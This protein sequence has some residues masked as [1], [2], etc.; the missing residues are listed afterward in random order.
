M[1]DVIAA[2]ASTPPERHPLCDPIEA[3]T[4]QQAQ[5]RVE[6]LY[7]LLGTNDDKMV[8][9]FLALYHLDQQQLTSFLASPSLGRQG[10]RTDWIE[11]LE[12]VVTTCTEP[13]SQQP[14][15][16]RALFAEDPIPFEEIVLPFLRY[17]RQHYFQRT[18]MQE[19]SLI[20]E[21]AQAI[22]EHWLL[23]QLAQV[24]GTVFQLEFS[25]FRAQYA[26]W[27]LSPER[28]HLYHAFVARYRGEGLLSFFQEYSA[29]ARLLILLVEQWI[30]TCGEFVSRLAAD[31]DEIAR[32]FH[33]GQPL[34]AVVK[35]Q[36]GCSDRHHHGRTVFLLSFAAGMK[37]VYK[38]RS[39]AVDQAFFGL[40]TWCNTQGLS[41]SLE[42]LHVLS[43]DTYGWME[44]AEHTSCTTQQEVE[45]Y[46][47]RAGM[48][49]CML[50]VLGG[51]DMH[52][53]N[54]VACGE[55]PILI[56]LETV[57]APGFSSQM[58]GKVL[59]ACSPQPDDP[60][61]LW[62]TVL[63]TS[64]LP[65]WSS[66]GDTDHACDI[67][68][69]GGVEGHTH[70][71]PHRSWKHINTDAMRQESSEQ[72]TAISL[73]TVLLQGIPET[74]FAYVEQVVTGFCRLYQFLATHQRELCAPEGPLTAFEGCS[75]R[76]VC[77]GTATYCNALSILN[78]PAWLRE[79][80][81]RWVE[82]QAFNQPWLTRDTNPCFLKLAEA[83]VHA[84]ECLDVPWFGTNT[85]SHDLS[86]DSGETIANL[87]PISA[88]E[89]ARARLVRL[90]TDDMS[91]QACLIRSTFLTARPTQVAV[92]EALSPLSE[93]LEQQE[94]FSTSQLV[95]VAQQIAQQLQA[96]AFLERREDGTW[97]GL[98]YKD[99]FKSFCVQPIGFNLYEGACGIALFLALL[100]SIT[101][102]NRYRELVASV[103][104]P[105]CQDLAT[106]VCSTSDLSDNSWEIG[107]A[108][109]LGSFI[110]ALTHIGMWLCL[111]ELHEAARQ[112]A[113]L[114]TV[115]RVQQDE[116]FDVIAGSAGAI[117]GLLCLYE[118]SGDQQL[119]EQALWC[120]Q[121]LLKQ[122]VA[123]QSGLRSWPGLKKH[124]LT[125][126]SHGAAGIA[127]AL[128]RLCAVSG[129]DVLREA[130]E[131]AISFERDLFSPEVGNWPD[132]REQPPDDPQAS[133]PYGASWCHGAP[134][135]GLARLGGLAV[136]DTPQVRRDLTTA[137]QTTQ[138][139]GLLTLDNLC[140]GNFGRIELLVAASQHLH[141]PQLLEMARRWS[142][143]LICRARQLDGFQMFSQLPR[144][145]YNP[146]L[147][148][149]SAGIGYQ[150]LRVAFPEQVPSILL[151]Q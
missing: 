2:R 127:Y 150:L 84:L 26:L 113:S 43:R 58:W 70:L 128:L 69:L 106:A 44:Y 107:G 141:Q 132:L 50:Y 111:P 9:R 13:T 42:M 78:Q 18:P 108:S 85:V 126:F 72:P 101:G 95:E 138:T 65:E 7:T 10:F 104:R 81:D 75:L 46:Y 40:L 14:D 133:I 47:L 91:R 52:N 137:L 37:L 142:S 19:A 36:M 125:G 57:I 110:Y 6:R 147:F 41:P 105:L 135:I 103:L 8:Q 59:S 53:S 93:E 63:H 88:L 35:L 23:Q 82:L 109:G 45:N 117:L 33:H 71:H 38:P 16:D 151:W 56:D 136:L 11:V 116:S 92:M 90:H 130:A 34:G 31:Q 119:I 94:M 115:A 28:R 67:S 30:E 144:R 143:A 49:L 145:A 32:L 120:A 139:T 20:C 48:L 124:P 114:L 27:G 62:H 148:Q 39:L 29:L 22:M 112:A 123:M 64:F 129:Q 96:H 146:G 17:A 87:F 118:T 98:H 55:H 5:Q 60:D 99:H 73:N 131:E 76:F 21:Q 24:A 86:T 77:C 4:S 51:T 83:E 12:Q 74:P 140:C 66:H 54:L 80:T 89:R 15:A 3:V 25:L 100:D 134:G 122:R 61:W 79:G 1:L 149:G 102:K 121:H 97:M 68:G